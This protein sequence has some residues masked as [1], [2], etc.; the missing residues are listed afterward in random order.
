MLVPGRKVQLSFADYLKP[1]DQLAMQIE[2]P[3]NR[4]MGISASS[5]LDSMD[6]P[7]TLVV[8]MGVLP[9]GTIYTAG[10]DLEA[11]AKGLSA[12]VTNDG[13]RRTAN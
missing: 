9:D 10:I 13:Y 8:T 3:T 5:Y 2:L 11:K 1:G 12:K 7:V 6:D 4:M